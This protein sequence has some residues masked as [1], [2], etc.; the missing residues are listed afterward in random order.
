M[1]FAYDQDQNISLCYFYDSTGGG[2][3]TRR[4]ALTTMDYFDDTAIVGDCIYFG[5]GYKSG[6][7]NDDTKPF[8]DLTVNVGTQLAADAITV[9]WEYQNEG[10]STWASLPNLTDNTNAFQNAGSATVT[11]DIP[12]NW[13][14]L[15]GNFPQT[16]HCEDSERALWIRCRISAL[17]NLTEGGANQTTAPYV[18]D[19]MITCT[20]EGSLTWEGLKTANDAGA[21]GVVTKGGSNQFY[22]EANLSFVNTDLTSTDEMVQ[23]GQD[24]Y[25]VV[26]IMNSSSSMRVGTLDT[27]RG[28]DGGAMKYWTKYT[29]GG[30]AWYNCYFYGLYL[31]KNAGAWAN[32]SLYDIMD[33]RD[34]VVHTDYWYWTSGVD[35]GSYFHNSVYGCNYFFYCYTGNMAIDGVALPAYIGCD[36]TLLGS[37]NARIDNLTHTSAQ[38]LYRYYGCNVTAVNCDFQ[39]TDWTN[40]TSSDAFRLNNAPS[41]GSNWFVKVYYTF[42]LTIVDEEG[43]AIRGARVKLTD[44]QG[45]V[46][47]EPTTTRTDQT[48][49]SAL[50]PNL[51]DW[52]EPPNYD[53][54]E[55]GRDVYIKSGTYSGRY[56]LITNGGTASWSGAGYS[57]YYLGIDTV[58]E[59]GATFDVISNLTD[60]FGQIPQQELLVWH[61]WID[62]DDS[63]ARNN[64][65]YK[66]YVLNINASGYEPYEFK[67]DLR[68]S[69]EVDLKIVLKKIRC[70]SQHKSVAQI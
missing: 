19:H 28:R 63:W 22:I 34:C 37:G 33:W 40:D 67:W 15:S 56:G 14:Y 6:V 32:P 60:E 10:A 41:A 5:L 58:G 54:A 12:Q 48:F 55:I 44:G 20:D 66:D 25:E 30:T 21:W 69:R 2:E 65:D 3:F 24:G 38:K 49:Y 68:A 13:G 35:A 59:A 8:H 42:D 29:A 9:V 27:G 51:V 11:F 50:T 46:A 31:Y 53:S 39:N 26:F 43:N 70:N 1:S 57:F 17:T 4:T 18:K 16:G 64:L 52:L 61:A 45:G 47:F 7:I 23:F 36:G 62:E